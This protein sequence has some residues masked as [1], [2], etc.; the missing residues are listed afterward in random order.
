MIFSPTLGWRSKPFAERDSFKLNS[1]GLR[2]GREYSFEMAPNEGHIVVVG[3][4]YTFAG[5]CDPA[6]P[7]IPDDGIFTAVLERC[8]PGFTVINLGVPGARER[9]G[10]TALCLCRLGGGGV[11]RTRPS[12]RPSLPA[13]AG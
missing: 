11:G 13:P 9:S 1:P 3:D 12:K 4:S 10:V 7:A 8:L 5:R 6:L 2:G